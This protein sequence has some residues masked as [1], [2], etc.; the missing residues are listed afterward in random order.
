MPVAWRPLASQ[1]AISELAIRGRDGIP[2]NLTRGR[3]TR[4]HRSQALRFDGCH[5]RQ[6]P[7]R[8]LEDGL[9]RVQ[10]TPT[11]NTTGYSYVLLN[12]HTTLQLRMD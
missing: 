10:L 5:W 12:L 8:E 1:K 6:A 9:G 7:Y 3:H 2:V 11:G 4:Y